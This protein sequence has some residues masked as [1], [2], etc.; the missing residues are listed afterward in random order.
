MISLS[1]ILLILGLIAGLAR[2][3]KVSN[4]A[5]SHFEK[6]WLVFSGLAIQVS[7]E[8]YAA[9]VEESLREGGRGIAILAVSYVFL[10]AFV[11]LNRRLPGAWLI[12]AG[13]GLNLLVIVPN[14]GMPVS[15]RAAEI[16]GFDPSSYLD[17]AIKHREMGPDTILWFLGDVIPM[18]FIKKVV[19]VGD[20]VLGMGVFLLI[21]RLVRYSP[22]RLHPPGEVPVPD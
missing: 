2:G 7:A 6:S 12:A 15:L 19:S 5:A 22:K 4:I 11:I 3:G 13:L 8:L 17:S 9:F 1:V 21:E 18:P 16:A 20:L 14:G 10:I